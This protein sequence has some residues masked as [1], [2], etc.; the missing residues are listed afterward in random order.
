MMNGECDSRTDPRYGLEAGRCH[1]KEHVE[2]RRCDTCVNGYWN[3]REGNE[4]GCEGNS[5][6]TSTFL[7]LTIYPVADIQ[8]RA[9]SFKYLWEVARHFE[10]KL[11]LGDVLWTIDFCGWWGAYHGNSLLKEFVFL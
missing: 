1:C 2:G 10:L 9:I 8:Y 7:L 5:R 3:L 4:L 11:L 6:V